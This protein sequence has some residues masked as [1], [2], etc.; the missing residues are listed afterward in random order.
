MYKPKFVESYLEWLNDYNVNL[1]L[2][3]MVL[4]LLYSF[5]IVGCVMVWIICADSKYFLPIIYTILIG[6]GLFMV[7]Y[8]CIQ[9]DDEAKIRREER[10]ADI[11][12]SYS[13]YKKD[14]KKFKD[15]D[16]FN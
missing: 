8:K 13:E 16:Y 2:R 6:G 11:A 15:D 12:D 10:E 4:L 5:F 7:L 1:Y 9:Y 3:A 14:W